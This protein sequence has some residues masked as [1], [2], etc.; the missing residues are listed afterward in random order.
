M[1]VE[2]KRQAQ[3]GV[4]LFAMRRESSCGR[5]KGRGLL[6]HL[7]ERDREDFS[8]GGRGRGGGWERLISR[9]KGGRKNFVLIGHRSGKWPFLL[10][11]KKGRVPCV[12]ARGGKT[13]LLSTKERGEQRPLLHRKEE[14]IS[15]N[16]K[17]GGRK[18][19]PPEEGKSR[20]WRRDPVGGRGENKRREDQM[21]RGLLI[22]SIKKKKGEKGRFRGGEDVRSI[23]SGEK[24]K[25]SS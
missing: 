12:S 13:A 7:K 24:K 5:E 17:K 4:D 8:S 25:L 9:Q 6:A 3:K 18:I 19:L 11:R 1:T 23:G 20:H 2:R 21:V 15:L 14:V 16:T 22:L 10:A